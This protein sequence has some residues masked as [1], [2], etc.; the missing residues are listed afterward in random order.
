ML[1]YGVEGFELEGALRDGD[2]IAEGGC[3]GCGS[4]EGRGGE[5]EEG[6]SE[7]FGCCVVC[8]ELL[9]RRRETCLVLY[10]HGDAGKDYGGQERKRIYNTFL[11]LVTGPC[12]TRLPQMQRQCSSND[13]FDTTNIDQLTLM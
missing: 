1:G 3:L 10:S 5:G 4:C 13:G 8:V 7:H 11:P 9:K 6:E 12:Y 2:G